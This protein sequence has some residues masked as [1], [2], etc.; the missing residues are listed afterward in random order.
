M[1][2]WLLFIVFLLVLPIF[3]KAESFVL[4]LLNKD[5]F[6]CFFNLCSFPDYIFTSFNIKNANN[7]LYLNGYP[8]SYYLNQTFN[9]SA[10]ITNET[11]PSFNGNWSNI[12]SWLYNQT[13]PSISWVQ[14]QNYLTGFSESDPYYFSNPNGYFND[15]SILN[16]NSSNYSSYCQNLLSG[17]HCYNRSYNPYTT[18]KTCSNVF[19]PLLCNSSTLNDADF[20]GCN[21]TQSSSS[22]WPYISEV[23]ISPSSFFYEGGINVTC[24]FVQKQATYTYFEYV[25]YWNSSNWINIQNWTNQDYNLSGH[26]YDLFNRSVAFKLNYS[27]SE[28]RVRC[29]L[30]FNTT[31][32]STGIP[33]ECAN[34]TYSTKYDNDDVNFTVTL[35]TSNI[36][37]EVCEDTIQNIT[38]NNS[39]YLNGYLS[40]YFY[41]YSNPF[42]FINSSA[43]MSYY[44]V[45]NPFGFYNSTTQPYYINDT[46]NE[47]YD[48]VFNWYYNYSNPFNFINQTDADLL[49]Y[50]IDNPFDFYNSTTLPYFINNTYNVTY[51]SKI[52]DTYNST[53]DSYYNHTYNSTYD[54]YYNHTYNSTY[55]AFIVA[56]ISSIANNSLYFNGKNGNY[57][58]NI[59]GGIPFTNLTDWDLNK[60]WTNSLGAGN[61]TSGTIMAT[62]LASTFAVSISNITFNSNFNV[63]SKNITFQLSAEAVPICQKDYNS[64]GS[65][66]WC[67]CYNST[68]KWM[69][70]TC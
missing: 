25:W 58:W 64:T 69:A 35:N 3:A 21:G 57:F 29:I 11:E 50:P 70:N 42:N 19:S 63:T 5:E 49:Y 61:I 33:N 1:K 47:T 13:T 67:D 28:Q 54:S 30:H 15:S 4:P 37:Y 18:E 41:P 43:N 2:I 16:V 40:S 51:D 34:S 23:Y 59:T 68:H 12:S 62:Q 36:T 60:A 31:G 46:Y 65:L 56:N 10:Y 32:D 24:E 39:I 6:S 55:D 66:K 17:Y 48:A 52:N 7:S 26:P 14:A 20:E 53:Y 45:S 8:S 44:L 22:A 9:T 38:T 27:E